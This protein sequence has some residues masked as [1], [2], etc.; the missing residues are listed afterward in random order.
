MIDVRNVSLII[1]AAL[2]V[3]GFLF[4]MTTYTVRFTDVA[5][6]T[7]FG[8]AGD[9]SRVETPGL[10]FKWP[11]PIQSTTVYDN[12]VRLLKTRDETQQ[13]ADQRQLVVGAFLTWRINDPLRFY[14]RWRGEAGADPGEHF[15]L[16]ERTL[17]PLFRSAMSEVSRFTMSDLFAADGSSRILELEEA[18]LARL[19]G[20]A[21]DAGDSEIALYGIEV[22]MVGISSIELPETATQQVFEKM[23][24][25]RDK[26]AADAESQ[27]AARANT[28]R[29][30]AKD[31]AQT[32]LAFAN[33]F[34][35]EILRRGGFEAARWLEVMEE[36]PRLAA[37]LERIDLMRRGFGK[38][39]T[40]IFDTSMIGFELFGPGGADLFFDEQPKSELDR[41]APPESAQR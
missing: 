7:T 37:F 39:V 33:N 31:D 20:A 24:S 12:R 16:A 14:R 27:G 15:R 30:A 32:I 36:E 8:R 25:T 35:S 29:E 11:A 4:F 9:G 26:L 28:I 6:V 2:I 22:A 19:R 21:T 13:T 40:L 1:I 38:R 10:K 23:K 5:I 34:A 41:D 3:V 17:E 18:I